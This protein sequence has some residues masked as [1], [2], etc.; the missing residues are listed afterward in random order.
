MAPRD[1]EYSAKNT[2][3]AHKRRTMSALDAAVLLLN[4]LKAADDPQIGYEDNG[5]SFEAMLREW[6]RRKFQLDVRLLESAL[7]SCNLL[8]EQGKFV[9][10]EGLQFPKWVGDLVAPDTFNF[11]HNYIEGTDGY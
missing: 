9:H 4:L 11:T 1:L 6:K 10:P 3:L 2:S 7:W 5:R 8:H